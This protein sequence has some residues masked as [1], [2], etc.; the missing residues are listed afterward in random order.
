MADLLRTPSAG[1]R[2]A[3]P[4]SLVAKIGGKRAPL[5]VPAYMTKDAKAA[6]LRGFPVLG[7]TGQSRPDLCSGQIGLV[8]YSQVLSDQL[9]FAH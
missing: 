8:S 5:T 7:D 3:I 9:R 2:L 1:H 6:R 4:G